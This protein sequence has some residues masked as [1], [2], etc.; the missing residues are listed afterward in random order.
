MLTS[1]KLSRQIQ[2]LVW[3]FALTVAWVAAPVLAGA[4]APQKNIPTPA[5][6]AEKWGIDITG[7]HMSAHNYMVDFRYRVLDA[8]KAKA[9]FD[10]Q[11]K[12]Y[13]IDQASGKVLA[14]PDTAKLGPLR[15][16]NQPREGKIYWMFFGNRGGTV[17]T[18]STV[19]VK[20]GDFE[21]KDL[22]VK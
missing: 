16:S 6:L 8:E 13:L 19:T 18:G 11:T 21:A 20:I 17:D 4:A 15:N 12:P 9:L 10:R 1:K 22:V 5:S 7:I 3:S 2:R 14:V